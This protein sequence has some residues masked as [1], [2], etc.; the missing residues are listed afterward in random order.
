MDFLPALGLPGFPKFSREVIPLKARKSKEGKCLLTSEE[1][2]VRAHATPP[3]HHHH[4]HSLRFP[5]VGLRPAVIYL[6]VGLDLAVDLRPQR[7]DIDPQ[8]IRLPPSE[9]ML[10]CFRRRRVI[11]G[12]R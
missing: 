6:A 3:P 5:G 4:H 10:L 9:G 8:Q 11:G 7:N 1:E 2:E 12:G